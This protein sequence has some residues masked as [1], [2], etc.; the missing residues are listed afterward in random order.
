MKKII[1][2][3]L[4]LVLMLASLLL[5]ASAYTVELVSKPDKTVF[6]EGLDWVYNSSVITP[7]SD[8]DLTGTVIKY[9]GN[10]ISFNKFPWGGNM[11]A[12]PSGGK[13]QTGKNKV[14]IYLDDF[15]GVYVESELTLVA[16]KKA[17][18]SKSPDKTELIR[19]TDWEYDALG[20]ISLKKFTPAGAQIKL[21][22]TDGTS[23]VVS[24]EDGGMDWIVPGS[25]D[26]FVLGTNTLEL[27]YHGHTVPFNVK[28]VL[29]KIQ[30]ASL[31]SKPSKVNYDFSDD[32]KYSN[33]KIV[34][35]YDFSGLKVSITYSNGTNEV[36]D[37]SSVQ[38][39]F[40]ITAPSTVTLGTNKF[41]ATVDG[42][43]SVEFELVIRGF[44]DIDF[45][46]R[47]NSEDALSVL[48]YSVGLVKFNIVKY[49]Y[50]DVTA[51]DKVNSSDALAILQKAVGTVDYFKSEL[52]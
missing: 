12:E 18:L 26:D 28:F 24:Y 11:Y 32:W 16:I 41:T 6:Y 15:D 9:N 51:D 13:W 36:I 10:N 49:K 4:C 35:G 20:S 34:P 52:V 14:K 30:S 48:Q 42:K 25:V 7:M 5:P 27:T 45:D 33:G 21:T 8:F 37:Y 2:I 31:K 17:E 1:S 3:S 50:S 40:K 19:G 22:F 46:G 43:A 23:K 38:S 29:E 39:R 44:G 47:I